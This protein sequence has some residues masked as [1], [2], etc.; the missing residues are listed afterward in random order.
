MKSEIKVSGVRRILGAPRGLCSTE[1]VR[2]RTRGEAPR[3][4]SF[5]FAP[6]QDTSTWC[7][8]H[9]CEALGKQLYHS[10]QTL[11]WA[12]PTRPHPGRRAEGP[13][14]AWQSKETLSSSVSSGRLCE[15]G[16]GLPGDGQM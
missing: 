15:G 2:A 12:A 4:P 14:S 13:A 1:E 11:V 16:E 5:L 10:I 6:R 8:L 9:L 3:H 7:F